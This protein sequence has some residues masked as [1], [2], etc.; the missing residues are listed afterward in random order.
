MHSLKPEV[1]LEDLAAKAVCLGRQVAERARALQLGENAK[2]VAFVS[3]CCAR[4]KE[5]QPFHEADE[6]GFLAVME[7]LERSIAAEY[8][9]TE[10]RFKV[11]GYD[12]FGPKGESCETQVYSDR[13]TELFELKCLFQDFLNCRDGVLDQVAAHRCLLNIMSS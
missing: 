5:R 10:D 9:G 6:G 8:L 11:T 12:E 3:R 7:I 1:N 13:G 4:L 2:D